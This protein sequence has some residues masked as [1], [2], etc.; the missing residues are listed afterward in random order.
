MHTCDFF[1]PAT[2]A[3]TE[4]SK[5]KDVAVNVAQTM[6]WYVDLSLESKQDLQKVVS[7]TIL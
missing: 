4:I 7:I 2:S 3:K 1:G 5:F 6:T